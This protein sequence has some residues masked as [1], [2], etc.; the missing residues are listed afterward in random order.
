MHRELHIH[1]DA[2]GVTSSDKYLVIPRTRLGDI[3]TNCSLPTSGYPS[4]AL[5]TLRGSVRSAL[6]EFRST[7]P[8]L[9]A[10]VNDL[11]YWHYWPLFKNLQ[12][13]VDIMRAN[14]LESIVIHGTINHTYSACFNKGDEGKPFLFFPELFY[15]RYLKEALSPFYSLKVVGAGPMRVL[16]SFL[17]RLRN[18]CILGV[19]V[20][21]L[22][23]QLMRCIFSGCKG[24]E[25]SKSD[26]VCIARGDVNL[27]YFS[28]LNAKLRE[29]KLRTLV[30]YD[31]MLRDVLRRS[32]RLPPEWGMSYVHAYSLVTMK[33]LGSVLTGAF[34]R[35]SRSTRV[36]TDGSFVIHEEFSAMCRENAMTSVDVALHTHL[37]GMYLTKQRPQV[38][39]S[40]ELV[41]PYV[42]GHADAAATAGVRCVTAQAFAFAAID[43][44]DCFPNQHLFLQSRDL[45][46]DFRR[47][48]P[49][50]SHE[51]SYIGDLSYEVE[52]ESRAHAQVSKISYFTQPYE[53]EVHVEI[54]EQLRAQFPGAEVIVKV[55]PRDDTEIYKK[56]PEVKCIASGQR[57]NAEI[58]AASDL[59]VS[60]CSSVLH[61][62]LAIGV[63]YIA[64]TF[65]EYE[66]EFSPPYLNSCMPVRVQSIGALRDLLAD[67]NAWRARFF[68]ARAQYVR[69][70]FEP[71]EPKRFAETALGGVGL[72]C[73][74]NAI[75]RTS[76]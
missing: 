35:F 49:E 59:V 21:L 8:S 73:Q 69:E 45:L 16:R 66:K 76:A 12:L 46:D 34:R 60:R 44:V 48:F 5:E 75:Q 25:A 55:H 19:K 27:E 31:P 7:F 11:F 30:F 52:A 56:L 51:M 29:L 43:V 24:S 62:A 9:Y 4:G 2:R 42:F 32:S 53:P 6:A 36:I 26:I 67:F 64:C 38:V 17:A 41:S 14:N 33:A 58:L 57:S 74:N 10:R 15:T 70:I 61:E 28:K 40:N 37:L 65:N 71:F 50:H 23:L 47:Q 39:V 20:T 63:P 22:I 54:I 68:T 13:I 72:A 1:F 3:Q 18:P